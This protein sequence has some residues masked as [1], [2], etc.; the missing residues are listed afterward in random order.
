MTDKNEQER[1]TQILNL[2]NN[3]NF[4]LPHP[5]NL[6]LAKQID[7]LYKPPEMN[8]L[9]ENIANEILKLTCQINCKV[10]YKNCLIDCPHLNPIIDSIL[11]LVGSIREDERKKMLS[12]IAQIAE[13]KTNYDLKA[14]IL[15]LLLELKA[16]LKLALANSDDADNFQLIKDYERNITK[17]QVQHVLEVLSSEVQKIENPYVPEKVKGDTYGWNQGFEFCRQQVLN[18]FKEILK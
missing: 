1:L 9:R 18:I 3:W 14:V 2:I 6:P 17:A 10:E 4:G 13:S 16:N 7:A 5:T 12:L 8:E 15:G 11:S